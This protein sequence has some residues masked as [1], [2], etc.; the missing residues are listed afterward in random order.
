MRNIA[1][2]A[3]VLATIIVACAQEPDLHLDFKD[4]LPPLFTFSGR[5]FAV[6]FE[7]QEVP[8]SKPLGEVDPFTVEG[9]AIWKI[10]LGS[11]IK[12]DDWPS[13]TYGEVP[14][15]FSQSVP[16]QGPPPQLA[17]NKL[18]LARIIA[19]LDYDYKSQFFFEVRNGRIVNVTDKAFGP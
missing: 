7:I 5:S 6:A 1:L 19:G 14:T 16:E 3:F 15:G 8:R 11:K 18:Y 9:R 4:K 13:I 12:A 17:E 10:T 2:I